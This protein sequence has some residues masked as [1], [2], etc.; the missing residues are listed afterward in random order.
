MPIKSLLKPSV[1]ALLS[2]SAQSEM[3]AHHL[4]IHLAN[5]LQRLGFFGSQK[6]FEK[7]SADELQ[8]YFKIRNYVNDMGDV[9]EVPAI[10]MCTDT[11]TSIGD[12][13]QIFYDTESDLLN[14][15]KEV[16]EEAEDFEDCITSIFLQDFIR[17]QI[18]S[19]GEAGDLLQ[20]YKQAEIGKELIEFDEH[21]NPD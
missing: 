3:Y 12:A 7:E 1:K 5:Q 10:E 9:L 2:K 6:Y 4:Y 20:K 13:L 17:I 11:V 16:Y 8:H 21:M 18:T 14:Q 19:T 15:Y